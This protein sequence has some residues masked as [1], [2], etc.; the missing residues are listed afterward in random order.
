MLLRGQQDICTF[1]RLKT[2]ERQKTALFSRPVNFLNGFRLYQNASIAPVD[3]R[4]LTADGAI[5]DLASM[6]NFSKGQ[7]L[8]LSNFSY[9]DLLE[10]KIKQIRAT[11]RV[12]ISGTDYFQQLIGM[13]VAHR[14]DY[15]IVY[16]NV[17]YF[18]FKG[19]W[20]MPTRSYAI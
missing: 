12:N 5:R 10:A 14:A 13:F 9:G 1:N 19:D 8:L 3:Q 20:P 16:P 2:P 17:V 11:N 18:N 15:A 6:L 7:L 4:F